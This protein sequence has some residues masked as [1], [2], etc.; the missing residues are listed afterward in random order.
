LLSPVYRVQDGR[1]TPRPVPWE[2]IA[3]ILQALAAICADGGRVMPP[4]G[5]TTPSSELDAACDAW[6]RGIALD[7]RRW[8]DPPPPLDRWILARLI[9]ASA[10]ARGRA[11]DRHSP[12][13]PL[14]ARLIE[15]LL[16]DEWHASLRDRWSLLME[17]PDEP[18]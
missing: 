15:G 9:S 8:N 13:G 17:I 12:P 2:A 3:E 7:I 1:V 18:D 11:R 16:I 10:L 14:S 5:D 6:C 4:P